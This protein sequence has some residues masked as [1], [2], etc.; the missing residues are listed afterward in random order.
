VTSWSPGSVS[1]CTSAES[2]SLTAT[3]SDNVGVT[4][5]EFWDGTTLKGTATAAPYT[6]AWTI[7]SASNGSHAWTAKAYDAAGNSAASS[8]VKIGSATCRGRRQPPADAVS[9]P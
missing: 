3:A 5:V 8:A 9:R 4:R 2:F 7:S 1:T 6:F